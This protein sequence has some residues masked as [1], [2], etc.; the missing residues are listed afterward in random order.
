MVGLYGN[1]TVYTQNPELMSYEAELT[2]LYRQ[3]PRT[4]SVVLATIL[5]MVWT[6]A[7]IQKVKVFRKL[8][9]LLILRRYFVSYFTLIATSR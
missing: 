6:S 8:K 3:C 4:C 2:L 9:R 5:N 1:N 7:G